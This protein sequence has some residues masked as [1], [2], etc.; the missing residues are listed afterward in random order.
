MKDST[1]NDNNLGYEKNT[2]LVDNIPLRQCL[3]LAVN[4]WSV[5]YFDVFNFGTSYLGA[6]IG[7]NKTMTKI[8]RFTG[9]ARLREIL[10]Y[11]I[12]DQIQI[13]QMEIMLRHILDYSPDLT[14]MLVKRYTL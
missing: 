1:E 9:Y 5:K 12:V 7:Q 3:I 4:F 2:I 13:P 11:I 6:K 10:S 8:S 14:M